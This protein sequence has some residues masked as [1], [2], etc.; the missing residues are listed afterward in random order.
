VLIGHSMGGLISSLVVRK[1]GDKLWSQFSDTDVERLN[2]SPKGQETIDRLIY[3]PPR[4]DISRVIFVA[5]PHRGSRLAF[6]PVASVLSRLIQLP[7]LLDSTDRLEIV[8]AARDEI[9]DLLVVPANSIRFL[10]A[11]SPLILSIQ[12]LPLAQDIPY[13]S[14]IGDRGLGNTPFSSDGV[15]PYSSSHLETAQSEKIVPSNH[16]ANQHPKAIEEM[17][18]ILLEEIGRDGARARR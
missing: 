13:H 2:L 17:R 15:V 14:I 10:K 1:G 8:G 7:H 16:G 12:Q 4:S 9:R 5:T 18:R 6:N 3:F 11:D